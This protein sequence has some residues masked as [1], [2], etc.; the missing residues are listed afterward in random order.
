MAESKWM[1]GW[2]KIERGRGGEGFLSSSL[3][4]SLFFEL[5]PEKISKNGFFLL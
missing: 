1:D 2:M 5:F 3:A 4:H